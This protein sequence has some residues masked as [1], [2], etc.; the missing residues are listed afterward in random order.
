MAVQMTEAQKEQQKANAD[1]FWNAKGV[2]AELSHWIK[3]FGPK[4]GPSFFWG[5]QETQD[6]LRLHYK[7][8]PLTAAQ[9]EARHE[10]ALEWNAMMDDDIAA[11]W[12]RYQYEAAVTNSWVQETTEGY[13]VFPRASC[14]YGKQKGAVE[15][16]TENSGTPLTQQML[17]RYRKNLPK[18]AS[19]EFPF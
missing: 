18:L 5:M 13:T 15:S 10:L 17:E 19:G 9:L 8:K 3:L 2:R 6:L 7:R 14:K 11:F 1:A 12:E 4:V 16:A